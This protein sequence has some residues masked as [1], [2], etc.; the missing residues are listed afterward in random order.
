MRA[1]E[2]KSTRLICGA[3]SR[4]VSCAFSIRAAV[5]AKAAV[6]LVL[7]PLMASAGQAQTAG[8][9]AGTAKT[10]NQ[11]AQT[12]EDAAL[13]HLEKAVQYID[14]KEFDQAALEASVGV[15]LAP[16]MDG[17]HNVLGV[18]LFG[19][20][21]FQGA[22]REFSKAQ[23]LDPNNP[24]YEKNIEEVVKEVALQ[25]VESGGG[26]QTQGYAATSF[27]PRT[28]HGG[29]GARFGTRD[30]VTC[31]STREPESGPISVEQATL[32]FMCSREG[33]RSG[34]LDLVENLTLQ[35]GKGRP[36]S[37][38]DASDVDHDSLVYPIR[39]SFRIYTC[40]R[41]NPRNYGRNCQTSDEPQATGTCYRTS[42][43]DWRCSMVDA[44]I[45][46]FRD[47]VPPPAD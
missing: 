6:P 14:K 24:Q 26:G 18:A 46:N 11:P 39:G 33:T 41:P 16:D 19:K 23:K 30:P 13:P 27:R 1:H 7:M 20:R 17:A 29:I 40:Y 32:Y 35:V 4:L 10:G 12:G 21:D 45:H 25:Y 36:A 5:V 47:Y 44:G 42:Y 8:H 37:Y 34:P 43:G 9:P 38:M 3:F 28:T 31:P 2:L 15:Q 22:L